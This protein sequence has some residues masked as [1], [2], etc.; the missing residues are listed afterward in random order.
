[1]SSRSARDSPL[2]L[3]LDFEIAMLFWFWT[4]SPANDQINDI[5]A[6][7]ELL[8][9]CTRLTG[10]RFL[11]KAISPHSSQQA[12]GSRPFYFQSDHAIGAVCGQ[13]LEVAVQK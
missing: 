6:P 7:Y 9:T 2:L 10:F 12:N 13:L 1:M 4:F 8:K 5:L 11:S 3:P